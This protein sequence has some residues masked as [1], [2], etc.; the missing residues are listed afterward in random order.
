[1]ECRELLARLSEFLEGELTEEICREIQDHME[2]CEPCQAFS[3]TLKRTIELCRQL[4]SKPLPEPV[5]Q[6]LLAFLKKECHL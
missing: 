5:K 3:R 2:G 4:P 6:E 1:M